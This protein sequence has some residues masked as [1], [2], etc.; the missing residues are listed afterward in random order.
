MRQFDEFENELK[1][2]DHPP[3]CE[4]DHIN[5]DLFARLA[6]LPYYTRYCEEKAAGRIFEITEK[7]VAGL[8][9]II[10][11]EREKFLKRL[12]AWYKRYGKKGIKTWTYLVD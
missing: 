1:G 8:K 7:D 9:K 3:V 5:T 6:Y 11:S 2:T 4:R 10:R 12:E